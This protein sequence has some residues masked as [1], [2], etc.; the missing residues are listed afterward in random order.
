MRKE[1][2]NISRKAMEDYDERFRNIYQ[3]P[4]I[5]KGGVERMVQAGIDP[6]A[7]IGN[8]VRDIV[9]ERVDD[10]IHGQGQDL[11]GLDENDNKYRMIPKYYLS[12]LENANDVSHDFAYS[13][14]MLSLQATAYKY[15]RAA[16]DDVMGYRNMMLETQYDGGKNP[17]ATHAYRMFQ[18]WVN[19]SIYDVRIN[20]K[21]A[22]WNI[23]NYKVDLNKLALMFTKF[24][25]KSN[26]GFSPFVAATGALTGQANFLL[27][28]MVGQY[29]SKDSM[30]YAYGEAQKQLSTYVSEIGDINRTNKLYVV[31]EALGVFN[32]RNRVRSAAY[33][34][35][36]RTLFRDLPFKMM[37]VLNSPLDPQVIISVMDDTRLYEGQFWSYSN[38]KEMMMK[39]R[40]M[41]ASEAKR[42]WKRLR[43]YSMWNMVDVKDG[44]IVAKNEANKDIIDRYIP[45]LSSRVRSMVQICDGALNEQNRVGASRNAILNM[46]LPH[47]GWFILAVQRAY[48]KAGFNFQTNQFEEGYMRTLWRLAGNVYG[49]MSEGR[50]GEAYDVLKEEY[51]KLTPYE[52]INIKRSIINMAVFATMMAIG[53]A[54]MGYREDNEDSWF[55]QFI[56][57]I[58]FRTINE[59]ASQTSPFMELNAIDMLQDPL[60]TA[61]KLGD[62]TDPRNWDP[63]ATVQTG[64]YKGESKLWRQL[65]KFSFGKQWYNIKTARDI[66]QTSDYWLMTNGMTMGFFLGGRNKDESGEDANWYFDRGR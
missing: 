51:D 8:A 63:F 34:K 4:Q 17:E 1:L 40:N 24:V 13:Y 52:Q 60:V 14:S 3:I 50:M 18:D 54:L 58:G 61:R 6:K 33:N 2:L 65:M 5:S 19:A 29:I 43:D 53:R 16:L 38:F 59:I 7:A 35:I 32:V 41:S 37:E 26:L 66:K 25:S 22:E 64:V 11:G 48:K 49:S 15:K 42:D 46:V 57:Y 47:R 39:D 44:K 55:G 62:L 20:N 23:G 12:K 56:T 9:G 31:G 10:P 30:K 45:T 27:E 21:R 28:G 36:W